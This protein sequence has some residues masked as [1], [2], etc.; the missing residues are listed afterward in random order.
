MQKA[1]ITVIFLG[2]LFACILP[3]ATGSRERLA[4]AE[5]VS[6]L[7]DNG[8]Q[9]EVS[10]LEGWAVLREAG[11]PREIWR[12]LGWEK[13][14]GLANSGMNQIDT[15][16]GRCMNINKEF[17]DGTKVQ[18]YIQKFE[19]IGLENLCYIVVK[20]SIPG[21]SGEGPAWEKRLRTV[22]ANSS[23]ERGLYVTVRGEFYR[24]LEPEAQLAWGRTVYRDLGG[25][26]RNTLQT[27]RYLSLNGYTAA[28]PDAVTVDKR[29][30]NLNV[31]LVNSS[32]AFET[33]VYL[34][35]P[36]ITSEY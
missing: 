8:V 18:I 14:L 30:F 27:E 26:I 21:G 3:G 23:R 7:R 4:L 5:L 16:R 29:K 35:S 34:G 20:C 31:A 32:D 10:E 22:L 13:Q 2:A 33:R 36:I 17:Q 9:V 6:L 25:R 11:E 28:L 15:D 12:K 19:K 24:R 1:L